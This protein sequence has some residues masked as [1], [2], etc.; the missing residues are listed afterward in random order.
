LFVSALQSADPINGAEFPAN[1]GQRND[2]CSI[3]T[4]VFYGLKNSWCKTAQFCVTR[5]ERYW[6]ETP[7]IR[8][9]AQR[10][11]NMRKNSFLNP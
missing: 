2:R 9:A 4:V 8:D 5:R 3:F 6:L 1:L 7:S 11:E 10:S